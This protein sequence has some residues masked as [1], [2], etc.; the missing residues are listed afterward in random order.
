MREPGKQSIR[1]A[2]RELFK[3]AQLGSATTVRR[4]VHQLERSGWLTFMRTRGRNVP[5]YHF[6]KQQTRSQLIKVPASLLLDANLTPF[7]KWFYAFL[8]A[9]CKHKQT[10]VATQSELLKTAGLAGDQ[11]LRGAIAQLQHTGWLRIRRHGRSTGSM[12]ELLDPH[13][14]LR[15]AIREDIAF[16]LMS[17]TY[18]GES[19]LKAMLD[20]LVPFEPCEDNAQPKY[21]VNLS[22][23]QL[24]EFDRWYPL[25]RVAIEFNGPQHYE[26]TNA[27]PDPNNVLQQ[28]QRDLLKLAHAT[29]YKTHFV[30]ITPP[31]LTFPKLQ[32]IFA[33]LLPMVPLQPEDPVVRFLAHYSRNYARKASRGQFDD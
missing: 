24:M 19:L 26:P 20:I 30:T 9:Y 8:I 29:Q 2:D 10:H 17:R 4:H 31:E 22:T 27:F 21:L 32:E 25:A 15:E 18:K 7:A 11:A 14:A 23:G 13:W 5:E 33:G 6:P 3:Q 28:R 12:Y 16:D 1:V